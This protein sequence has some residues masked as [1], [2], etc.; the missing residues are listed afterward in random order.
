MFFWWKSKTGF[1]SA[2]KKI[3]KK[4]LFF[5]NFL[6]IFY[7]GLKTLYFYIIDLNSKNKKFTM[8]FFFFSNFFEKSFTQ[9]K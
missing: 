7:Q 6:D 1:S 4:N 5:M 8:P 2:L 9:Y 3:C